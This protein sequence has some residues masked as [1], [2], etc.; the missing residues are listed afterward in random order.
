[1]DVVRL[2][3]T[4]PRSDLFDAPERSRLSVVSLFPNACRNANGKS[5]ESNGCSARA[6]IA[7]SI[8]TAFM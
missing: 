8:S 6:D 5:T 1:M 2:K 7:S 4:A 3:Y